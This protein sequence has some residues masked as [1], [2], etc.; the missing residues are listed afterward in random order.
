MFHDVK[1][2]IEYP[3]KI[4]SLMRQTSDVHRLGL[5]ISEE[6]IGV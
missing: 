2:D 5:S 1:T 6:N 4:R 3:N